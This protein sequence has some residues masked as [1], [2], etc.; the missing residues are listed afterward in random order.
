[1]ILQAF[2]DP[3]GSQCDFTR[4]KVF[5][6]AFRLVVEQN[7]VDREHVVR[8]PVFFRDPKIH[9][10]LRPRKENTDG[11][12]S[13][14]A[15]ALLP[16]FHTTRTSMPGKHGK[17]LSSLKFE[18]L[19]KHA[20]VQG[21]PHRRSIPAHQ[22]K[23]ARAIERPGCR[24]RWFDQTNDPNQRRRIRKISFMQRNLPKQ[25]VDSRRVGQRS[26]ADDAMHLISFL[27]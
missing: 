4:Y 10:V 23:P 14:R 7:A 11:T 25:M 27:Q 2:G 5:S 8:F 6:P 20:M 15:A 9:I 24:F 19:P 1:M 17:C 18:R 12:A 26:A 3:A 16:P 13:F 21:R 22:T